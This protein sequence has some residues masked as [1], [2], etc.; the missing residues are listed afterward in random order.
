[1]IHRL[2][3]IT[4][5][6][7]A[8]ACGKATGRE[9]GAATTTGASASGGESAAQTL[10]TARCD[11]EETCR[12]VGSG[13]TYASRNACM[14]ELRDKSRSELNVIDCPGGVDNAQLE[15]CLSEIRAEKCGNALDAITR[16]AACRTSALCVQ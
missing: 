10:A 5:A 8:L 7:L 1:M 3:C 12:N 15:K 2:F 16:L 6:V 11:R 13:K 4:A 14:D 9:P